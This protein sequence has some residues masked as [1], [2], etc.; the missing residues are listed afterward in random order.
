MNLY[1]LCCSGKRENKKTLLRGKTQRNKVL[2]NR[3]LAIKQHE[4]AV[5]LLCL[6]EFHMHAKRSLSI[7]LFYPEMTQ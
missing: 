6:C 7:K 5:N 4:G 1:C 3:R 2:E